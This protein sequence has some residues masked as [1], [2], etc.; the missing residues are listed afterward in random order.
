MA[1]KRPAP[2]ETSSTPQE[3]TSGKQPAPAPEPTV[4]APAKAAKAP[5]RK[6]P[7]KAPAVKPTSEKPDKPARKVAAPAAAKSR[8]KVTAKAATPIAPAAETAAPKPTPAPATPKLA[9]GKRAAPKRR[10]DE[11]ADTLD[12]VMVASE[13]HP[14]ATS[15]GLSEVLGALPQALT[16]LGHRVTAI[17][18]RYRRVPI[19]PNISTVNPTPHRA[20]P[21]ADL[22]ATIEMGSRQ[23]RVGFYRTEIGERLTAVFVDVP[24]LFD[25]DGLYGNGDGDYPDN[26]IRFAVF[27]RAAL[28]YLR[29]RGQRPSVIHVHDWQ[30]GLVPAY[31]KMLFSPDP[32]VGG[33]PVVFTIHNLAFQGIFPVGTL[34]EIGLP[35]DVLHVEAMEFYGRIS[36][37]KAGINFSERITTVSPTYS[38]EILERQHGFGFEGV[39][40]RRSKDLRGILNG[41]DDSRWNP[42]TDSYLPAR[43]NAEDLAGK[44]E[45]KRF[46]LQSSGL[47]ATDAGLARPLIGLVSRLTDQKGFDLISAAAEELMTLDAAWVMLGSGDRKYEEQWKMLAARFPDRVS[48]TIGYD[49]RLEHLIEGGADAFLMPSRFEPCGLNQLNS[50]RYGTLPIVRATGGLNDTVKDKVNG[51]PGTGFRFDDYTPDALVAAVRRALDVYETRDAW[52]E[53]QRAAMAGNF[54]WD[55]SAREYVK[56]YGVNS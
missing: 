20:E 40:A 19:G 17:I 46:L 3:S 44:T 50:L 23:F 52:R 7:A 29:L 51:R 33:V 25:R 32:I 31:Q 47:D 30:A 42:A 45:V 22:E 39:L 56:V 21:A 28:E 34:D 18:P 6:T 38:R 55:V 15:G 49:E 5:V 54:S 12:I 27:S 53:M 4:K 36:Y 24:E 16:R 41:I 10:A 37:L 8:P 35:R 26:A 9:T 2:Q 1:K 13:M 48:A 11:A 43:Y 14:F